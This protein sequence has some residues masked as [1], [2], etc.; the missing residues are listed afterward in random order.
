MSTRGLRPQQQ[1]TLPLPIPEPHNPLLQGHTASDLAH[2][3]WRRIAVVKLRDTQSPLCGLRHGDDVIDAFN[4]DGKL[5]VLSD[6]DEPLL[7]QIL[8][9][10]L[11]VAIRAFQA[12]Q[13]IIGADTRRARALPPFLVQI[14]QD[15]GMHIGVAYRLHAFAALFLFRR[16]DIAGLAGVKRIVAGTFVRLS[17]HTIGLGDIIESIE[18]GSLRM[19]GVVYLCQVAI[20]DIERSRAAFGVDMQDRVIV[21][22]GM[23]IFH[24][25]PPLHKRLKKPGVRP[26]TS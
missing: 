17:Q 26:A 7:L 18:V 9:M 12:S 19:V 4:R 6:L 24:H 23:T 21:I 20:G 2:R 22:G 3:P 25:E 8:G 14:H 5:P 16:G 10:K 13:D 15:V 11:E 1:E